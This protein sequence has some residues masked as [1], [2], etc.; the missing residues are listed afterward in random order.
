MQ[1]EL[2]IYFILET[3]LLVKD[4]R[5]LRINLHNKLLYLYIFIAY[6]RGFTPRQYLTLYTKPWF[7]TQF[8]KNDPWITKAVG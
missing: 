4:I 1:L 5:N 2:F 8:F 7:V 3:F 6:L